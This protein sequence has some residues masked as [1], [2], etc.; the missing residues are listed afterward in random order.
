MELKDI[1]LKVKKALHDLYEKDGF[2]IEKGLCERCISHRFAVHLEKQN[3]GN[4]YHI[5]CEYNKSHL[6]GATYPKKVSSIYGN[7]IDTI[8]TKRDSDYRN[9]LVCFEV[10]RCKNYNNR[11]KDRKNLK[12]LTGGANPANDVGFGYNYGFY[13]IF[14]KTKEKTKIEI[15]KNGSLWKEGGFS[16][17][18]DEL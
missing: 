15:Y 18:S 2:I 7:Y 17:L 16:I 11:K 10:K 4:G 1:K 12:I 13:I 5:D 9:D 3:F 14:G 8:I 6:G